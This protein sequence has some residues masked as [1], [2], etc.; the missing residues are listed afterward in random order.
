MAVYGTGANVHIDKV[1][2]NISLG[3]QNNAFISDSLFPMVMVQKQSDLYYTYGYE[4]WTE[5]VGGSSRAPGTEANEV[6]G[7]AVSTQTYFATEHALQIAVTDEERQNADTPLAPDRDGVELVTDQIHLIRERLV[8]SM[9][10]TASNYPS[11]STVTLSGTD[12]WSDLTNSAPIADVRTAQRAIMEVLFKEPNLAVIPYKVMSYLEDNTTIIDRIKYSMPGVL[13]ADLIAGVFG[14]ERV[15]VPGS[16]YNSAN[17]GQDVSLSYLWG[18]DVILAYVP[19]RAGMKLP[20]FGYEFVWGYPGGGAQ[21]VERWREE[22]RKSDV[23][24][25]SRRYDHQFIALNSSSETIAGYLI[26]AAIA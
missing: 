12:Q 3:Y 4:A 1:L 13:G 24:R 14:I 22:P 19:Q 6:P 23:I 8:A 25:V 7:L 2:T 21:V 9:V 16:G 10:T 11:G 26:K 5:P 17:P 20:A 15:V 18:N